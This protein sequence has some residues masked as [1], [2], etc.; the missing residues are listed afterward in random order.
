VLQGQHDRR[1]DGVGHLFLSEPQPRVGGPPRADH[2]RGGGG[3]PGPGIGRAVER[4][5]Y[6][7]LAHGLLAGRL[8]GGSRLDDR[9]RVDHANAEQH[10]IVLGVLHVGVL[11]VV[12]RRHVQCVAER[13]PAGRGCGAVPRHDAAG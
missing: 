4:R 3:P 5:A 13:V 9:I 6:D 7:R 11:E 12:R 10:D 2:G 1:W 8:V